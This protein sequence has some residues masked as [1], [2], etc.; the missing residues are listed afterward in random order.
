MSSPLVVNVDPANSEV[1]VVLGT[2]ITITFDQAIDPTTIDASTFS[3]TGPGQ[4]QILTAGQLIAKEGNTLLSREYIEGTFAFDIDSQ[5][6]SVVS[7][8]PVRHFQPNVR[9]EVLLLGLDASLTINVIANPAGEAMALS[10]QW[11]FQ[12]GDL[13]LTVPPTQSLLIDNTLAL[14]INPADIR[15]LPRK[16]VGADLT[17]IIDIIFPGPID[18]NSFSLEDV[19]MSIEPVMGDPG[20]AVPPNLQTWKYRL[21][22]LFAP[23]AIHCRDG[24]TGSVSACGS[25]GSGL[26][27]AGGWMAALKTMSQSALIHRSGVRKSGLMS[28]MG[29]EIWLSVIKRVRKSD[30]TVVIR[31]CG[32]LAGEEEKMLGW[33]S[34]SM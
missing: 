23:I 29:A 19:L 34:R 24:I 7:F 32:N 22:G 2:Q 13:N 6:R 14:A 15:L 8:V 3:V 27:P 17:Q 26:I 21:S 16:M 9:Y 4:T 31:R 11:S 1:D 18:P 33:G 5:G 25:G 28:E 12:T 20:I 10:Y 30:L